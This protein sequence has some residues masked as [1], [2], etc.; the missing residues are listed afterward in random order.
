MDGRE[1]APIACT[2]QPADYRER[3][4]VIAELA[5][6]GLLGVNREDL[7]LHLTYAP[8]VAD[9]VR[10]IVRQEQQCCAFL[11]FEM[12]EIESGFSLTISAPESARDTAEF[13]FEQFLGTIGPGKAL[14]VGVERKAES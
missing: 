1:E 2:L 9:R 11:H 4:K 6:D 5:R 7:R 3:I 12:S 13:L 10:Q 8:T 14:S